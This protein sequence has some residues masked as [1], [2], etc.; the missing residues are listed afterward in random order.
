[1]NLTILS[2]GVDFAPP[3]AGPPMIFRISAAKKLTLF[4]L[5]KRVRTVLAVPVLSSRLKAG[6]HRD[7]RNARSSLAKIDTRSRNCQIHSNGF[8]F[9]NRSFRNSLVLIPGW[10]TDERIFSQFDLKYNYLISGKVDP[11]EFSKVLRDYLDAN[12]IAKVSL[13]GYSMGGFMAKEFALS[14][15]DRVEE[16]FLISVR[17][18]YPNQ[19]LKE[20][21][22]QLKKNKRGFLYKFYLDCFSDSDKE[23]KDWFKK[24]LLKDYVKSMGLEDLLRGLD[25]LGKVEI[26][27]NELSQIKNLKMFHGRLDKIAPVEEAEELAGGKLDII[28]DAGHILF[29]FL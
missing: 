7:T 20:I 24:N 25:Y 3:S 13:F 21:E 27:A 17:K 10:A 5:A 9:I 8:N 18:K 26:S 23:G 11:L 12:S 22:G 1:M 14:N 15:P 2:L 19:Q 6:L 4:A 29:S 16:V 28:N